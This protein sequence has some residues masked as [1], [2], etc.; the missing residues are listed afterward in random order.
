[1]TY[2]YTNRVVWLDAPGDRGDGGTSWGLCA[3]H[4]ENLRVPRGWA[5]EDRRRSAAQFHP[6][7]AV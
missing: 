4:A 7:I 2:D 1:M 3:G 5:I 6:P